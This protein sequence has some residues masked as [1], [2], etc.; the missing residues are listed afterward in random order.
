M[1]AI[2]SLIVFLFLAGHWRHASDWELTLS[3]N[4]VELNKGL[5]IVNV[6]FNARYEYLCSYVTVVIATGV[7]LAV[8]KPDSEKSPGNFLELLIWLEQLRS[9]YRKQQFSSYPFTK[10]DMLHQHAW[11]N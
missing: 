1:K 4:Y 5:T 7:G 8:I 9:M 6:F 3:A 10:V 2:R 11:L